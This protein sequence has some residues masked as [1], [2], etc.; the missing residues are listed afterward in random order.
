MNLSK[1]RI[2]KLKG[3]QSISSLRFLNLS[4]NSVEKVLQLQHIEQ[5]NL[6]TELDFCFNPL[7]NKKHYRSQVLF[8]I[9]QL[10]SLDGQVIAA[11]EKIK[12]ENLHGVDLNDREKIFN[13]QLPQEKF[14]D[15][16]LFVFEDIEPESEDSVSDD[17]RPQAMDAIANQ[18][19]STDRER[20]G[21]ARQYVGELFSGID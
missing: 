16:R 18:T 15:R 17:E 2:I 19:A 5:L 20:D 12:A 21:V 8:H 9:P 10:R 4:L 3:L 7:Q 11:E 1:N 13:A 14:I 6:L